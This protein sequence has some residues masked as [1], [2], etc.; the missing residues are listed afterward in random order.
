LKRYVRHAKEREAYVRSLDE[1]GRPE[2]YN[3]L[4]AES[5]LVL[6]SV[7]DIVTAARKRG[8]PPFNIQAPKN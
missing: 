5:R 8:C 7:R 6:T 4:V 3:K 2:E 1:A